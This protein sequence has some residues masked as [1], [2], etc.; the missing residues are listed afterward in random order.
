MKR[1]AF[2]TVG[3]R[4]NQA[5]T[6]RMAAGLQ[7]AGYGIVPYGEACE[8]GVVHTCTITAQAARDSVRIARAW[9]RQAA[10]P[11]VILAGC[12]VELEP[13]RLLRESGADLAVRQADKFRLAELLAGA[14]PG[15]SNP[16]PSAGGVA[17]AP[18]FETTRALIH[19]QDG[20]DFRCAYC[21]VP[22]ARHA[23]T[24][25][26]FDDILDEV[27]RLGD[28]GYR[29]VVLTGAN[30]G[31]YRDGARGLVELLAAVEAVEA[32][33][34]MRVSSIELSTVERGLVDFMQSSAKFCRQLHLPLQSGDDGVLRAMGRR[35]T[36]C[37]YR[38]AV[39]YA[40]ERIPLLG[41]GADVLVG[42]PGE[43]ERA[44]ENTVALVRELPFSNLHVFPYSRRPG[45]PAAA[46]ADQ[47]PDREKKRRVR[48]LTALRDEKRSAL[49]A[50]H[51]GRPVEVLVERL[52]GDGAGRGW[53]GEY[54]EAVVR[55]A[56]VAVND[57][58]T[59]TPDSAVEGVLYA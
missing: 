40:L 16:S 21:V 56:G 17:A 24:S 33:R 36:A 41:L 45:T 42:F 27:R 22:L 31:C 32:V 1:V 20:C 3:C 37:A 52:C 10:P 7:A 58:V 12:A 29:E 50:R 38:E 19:V 34:R 59:C 51:I 44:F 47:V 30:L 53:T 57:I 39:A 8:I 18:L 54:V 2:K 25:R 35:Y 4:L 23:P 5:E 26:P 43:D 46:R 6:A 15:R 11:L 14:D 55:S 48:L 9:K 13:E 49:A 28:Q